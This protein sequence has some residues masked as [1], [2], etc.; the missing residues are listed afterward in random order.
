VRVFEGIAGI[1]GQCPYSRSEFVR[2]RL[3]K[4]GYL[5]SEVWLSP[6]P[7]IGVDRLP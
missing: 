5:T 3:V 6:P 4:L 7:W 1:D 2:I